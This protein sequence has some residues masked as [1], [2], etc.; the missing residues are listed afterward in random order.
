M[1]RFVVIIGINTTSDISQL[2]YVRNCATKESSNLPI[3]SSKKKKERKKEQPLGFRACFHFRAAKIQLE[4][5][6]FAFTANGK[7]EIQVENFS[8]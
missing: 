3:I 4:R 8:E 7:R 2:M 1:A 6:R 5:L